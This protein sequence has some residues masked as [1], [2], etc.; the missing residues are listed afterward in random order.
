[1]QSENCA[2]HT[3]CTPTDLIA[4]RDAFDDTTLNR[5][6]GQAPS[7]QYSHSVFSRDNTH[8]QM[9]SGCCLARRGLHEE[10]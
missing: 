7:T 5:M 6:F 10:D 8:N 9:C 4:G 1:M 3:T 2:L